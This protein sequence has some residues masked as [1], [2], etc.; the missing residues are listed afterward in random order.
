MGLYDHT[1]DIRAIAELASQAN[2]L[3]AALHHAP[4]AL[5]GVGPYDLAAVLAL[6]GEGLIVEVAEG[7]L[8]SDKVRQHRLRLRDFPSIVRALE[9]RKAPHAT[10]FSISSTG[11]RACWFR[12]TSPIA[13]SGSSRSIE[14][15]CETVRVDVRVIAASPV[16]F[17]RATIPSTC[18]TDR[19]DA[20]H[21][22]R[23][24]AHGCLIA[25]WDAEQTDHRVARARAAQSRP[26]PDSA[27]GQNLRRGRRRCNARTHADDT[28]KQ[29]QE[30]RHQERTSML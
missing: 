30:T 4:A 23:A 13:P 11:T 15:V 10:A 26:G 21:A 20:P 9:A 17:E 25:R 16:H 2:Q 22:W 1:R 28:A 14:L 5:R 27:Q 8:V 24:T 19:C 18:R 3:D 12:C 6:Q 29:A 7:P